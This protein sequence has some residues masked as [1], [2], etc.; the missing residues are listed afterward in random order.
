MM[1]ADTHFKNI[2]RPAYELPWLLNHLPMERLTS[3]PLTS[4][5]RLI[6]EAAETH[7]NNANSTLMNGIEA[8]GHLLFSAATNHD[9]PIDPIQ[10]VG[11]AGLLT[12]LAVEAQYL[13]ETALAMRERLVVV[14]VPTL[15]ATRKGGAA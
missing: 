6:A 13:Q 4:D 2:D 7:A 10:V 5:E 11:L 9:H 14:D 12:H 3:S 15:P 1:T 8:I